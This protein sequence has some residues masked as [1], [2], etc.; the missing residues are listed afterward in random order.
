MLRRS[1]TTMRRVIPGSRGLQASCRMVGGCARGRQGRS[2]P[3]CELLALIPHHQLLALIP[4]YQL[5]ALVPY[6]Q[7]LALLPSRELL[8]LVMYRE[9][10]APIPYREPLAL[11]ML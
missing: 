5:L 10:P 6:Y 1:M 2:R 8:A 4:Y 11:L 3:H 7:L 9:L